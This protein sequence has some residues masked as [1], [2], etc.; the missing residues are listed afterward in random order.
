[1]YLKPKIKP[2]ISCFNIDVQY[3]HSEKLY[4]GQLISYLQCGQAWKSAGI[5]YKS[6]LSKYFDG[7]KTPQEVGPFPANESE[8]S[9]NK[10]VV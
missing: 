9:I 6:V 3:G 2:K 7:C 1:M 4:F 8:I 5:S 10:R